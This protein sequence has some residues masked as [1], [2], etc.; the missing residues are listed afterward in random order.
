M[1]MEVRLALDKAK[2]TYNQDA[3]APPAAEGRPD[4]TKKAATTRDSAPVAK[5][6][7]SLLEQCIADAKNSAAK[8]E[9]KTDTRWS[10]LMANQHVKFDLL[11]TNVVAKKRN[12][13]LAFLMGTDTT[14]M[15][16]HVKPWYFVQRDLILNRM[17]A[18]ATTASATTTVT[19]PTTSAT[20]A[21]TTP[22]TPMTTAAITPTTPATPITLAGPT[23]ATSPT[24]PVSP[25]TAVEER[26]C[27]EPVV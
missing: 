15:D 16:E 25:V 2:E 17:M 24:T 10:A 7:Q 27:I 8:R 19:T 23:P 11:R 20:T 6:L 9:E 18:S 22:T 5:R 13:E 3:L 1:W 26:I 4:G 14:T 12:I 21:A